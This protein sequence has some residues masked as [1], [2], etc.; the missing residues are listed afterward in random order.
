MLSIHIAYLSYHPNIQFT[1]AKETHFFNRI[2]DYKRGMKFY[3]NKFPSMNSSLA[4]IINNK[5]FISVMNMEATPFYL[6]SKSSCG[7]MRKVMPHVKL[8][9]MMR[10]PVARA[11]SEYQMKSRYRTFEYINYV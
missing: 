7:R 1:Q 10:E 3:L 11:Y 4:D 2:D 6:A 9:I 5:H 8:I